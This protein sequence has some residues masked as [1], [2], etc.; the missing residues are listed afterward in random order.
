MKIK[1]ICLKTDKKENFIQGSTYKGVTFDAKNV[2][3]IGEDNKPH[4]MKKERFMVTEIE[5]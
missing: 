5:E 4:L 1:A 2:R 3:L